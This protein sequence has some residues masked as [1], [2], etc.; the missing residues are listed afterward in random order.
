VQYC[1]TIDD[2]GAVALRESS[3]NPADAHPRRQMPMATGLVK[4]T[5]ERDFIDGEF[6]L[7]LATLC[8][9][10]S[11]S[12]TTEGSLNHG[13]HGERGGGRQGFFLGEW[14]LRVAVCYTSP[15][16]EQ[17]GTP[18][19]PIKMTWKEKTGAQVFNLCGQRPSRA[20]RN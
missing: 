20:M 2:S 1:S 9:E 18:V 19:I 5:G 14:E 10:R 3:A 13:G 17:E 7:E 8:P 12:T 4:K 15:A 16:R 6:R 11:K